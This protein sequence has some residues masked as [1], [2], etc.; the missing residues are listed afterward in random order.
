M[1]GEENFTEAVLSMSSSHCAFN[2]VIWAYG[3]E[4]LVFG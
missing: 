1:C 2:A 3:P 4:K